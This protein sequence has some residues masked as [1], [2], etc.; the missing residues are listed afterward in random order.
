[1]YINRE[2]TYT[3]RLTFWHIINT[4]LLLAGRNLQQQRKTEVT[5]K[6]AWM[7]SR[8]EQ[9][10]L[11]LLIFNIN[12]IKDGSI[13]IQVGPLMEKILKQWNTYLNFFTAQ[14]CS[15][16]RFPFSD[17]FGCRCTWS[18]FLLKWLL[19]PL[20]WGLE[21]CNGSDGQVSSASPQMKRHRVEL[22]RWG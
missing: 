9:L 14:Q 2:D 5:T 13:L 1:M 20:T 10:Y 16:R 21:M 6:A 4:F 8:K 18:S 19:F 11:L 12:E 22:P 3:Y 7:K 15:E 17:H